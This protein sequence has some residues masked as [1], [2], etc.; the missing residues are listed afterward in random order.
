MLQRRLR[1]LRA[2]GLRFVRRVFSGWWEKKKKDGASPKAMADF[3]VFAE[4]VAELLRREG[5]GVSV[6]SGEKPVLRVSKQGVEICVLLLGESR[7]PERVS[8]RFECEHGVSVI[9][10]SS[11]ERVEECVKRLLEALERAG[12]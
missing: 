11:V 4:K 2:P 10:C 12:A 3:A 9:D 8:V 6:E 7:V 1:S 5:Y